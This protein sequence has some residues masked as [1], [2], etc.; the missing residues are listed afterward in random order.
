MEL[1]AQVLG[2]RRGH[3]HNAEYAA[4]YRAEHPSYGMYASAQARAKARGIAFTI[5]RKDIDD[6]LTGV[7][8]ALLIPLKRNERGNANPDS[9][10]LDRIDSTRGYEQGNIQVL[11]NKANRMKSDAT[12]E[13]LLLFA[14]WIYMTYGKGYAA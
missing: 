5:T 2:R 11:S 8:P 3:V 6:A 7:C 1:A 14:D 12:P 10:T 13:E 4:K 9:P